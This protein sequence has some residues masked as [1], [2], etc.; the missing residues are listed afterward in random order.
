MGM[1]TLSLPM[2]AK[3]SVLALALTLL[4]AS[5]GLPGQVL[6]Q[7][8][9][10]APNQRAATPDELNTY[11]GMASI[12]MCA[13]SQSKVPFTPAMQSNLNMLVSVLA[14]KH[15]SLVPGAKTPLTREQLTN[16]SLVQMVMRVD[17]I[18]GKNLPADW[19]KEF[20]PLLSQVKQAIQTSGKAPQK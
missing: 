18:C 9:G 5:I 8:Q 16:G 6:A 13:L 4:G 1:T 17:A 15:G 10:G 2:R 19:K 12:N 7:Q 3:R 11:I 14:S 20:D